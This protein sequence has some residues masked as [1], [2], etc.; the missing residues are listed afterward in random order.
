MLD[1]HKHSVCVKVPPT[2]LPTSFNANFATIPQ[3][4]QIESMWIVGSGGKQQTPLA[5]LI[6]WPLFD[7]VSQLRLMW[8]R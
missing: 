3:S 6:L 7:C 5:V 8:A 4:T 2:I 1:V